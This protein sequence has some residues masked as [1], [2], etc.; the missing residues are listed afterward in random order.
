VAR[1]LVAKGL[2][3]SVA[4]AFEQYLAAGRPG[5]VPRSRFAPEEAIGL[6]HEAGGVAVLAHPG[7]LKDP[8]AT[9]HELVTLGL[10]GVEVWHPKNPPRL[11]AE[12]LAIGLLATGGSDFHGDAKPDVALGQ[13]RV[14]YEVL[15][16]LRA[17]SRD[18]TTR[19]T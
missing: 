2:V 1:A 6:V 3:P 14:G 15:D 19:S 16:R 8:L 17:H 7:L 4:E 5:F 18:Q 10:D 12:L 9:L 13:E 11:R